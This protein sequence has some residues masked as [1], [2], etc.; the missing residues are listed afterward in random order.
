[1]LRLTL[2]LCSTIVY[3]HQRIS[4][5]GSSA[6]LYVGGIYNQLGHS[7]ATA[8]IDG[9]TKII[10]RSESA[11]TYVF[12]E[13]S[14]EMWQF[15]E[16]GCMLSEKCEVFLRELVSNWQGGGTGGKNGIRKG[17]TANHMV[18]VILYGRVI[19]EDNGEGEEE[20]APTSRN[21]EGM[22]YR[23]F[24]KVSSPV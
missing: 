22:I 5:A 8:L 24:Y 7:T 12:V 1:M 23:D 21:E 17:H 15:E 6:R 11:R 16:D 2:S 20:R 10:F 19:Y 14:A 4:L 3:H 9:D 18:S 13:V